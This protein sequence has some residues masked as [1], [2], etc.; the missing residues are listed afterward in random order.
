M[1]V[2]KSGAEIE[3]MASA[4]RLVADTITHVGEH[5][6]PGITTLQLDRIAE[7][8]IRSN[9]G[10]PTSMG[11]KGYPRAICISCH[12]AGSG[13]PKAFPQVVIQEHSDAGPCTACH[14]AHAAG[15]S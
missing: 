15:V 4:G 13:K 7:D 12:A 1:I 2:R 10:I 3:R 9:G 5:L 6:E 8:H 14:D 11:Y